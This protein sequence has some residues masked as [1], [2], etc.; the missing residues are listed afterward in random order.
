MSDQIEEAI[1]GVDWMKLNRCIISFSD[2]SMT[3]RGYCFPLIKKAASRVN[4]VILGTQVGD[5]IGHVTSTRDQETIAFSRILEDHVSC[6]VGQPRSL[7]ADSG[8]RV[9]NSLIDRSVAEVTK[10]GEIQVKKQRVSCSDCNQSFRKKSELTRHYQSKH[11]GL[12]WQCVD[13]GRIYKSRDNLKRHCRKRHPSVEST[14]TIGQIEGPS[15]EFD[16]PGRVATCTVI[17][18]SDE[19]IPEREPEQPDV[20][21]SPVEFVA[22]QQERF[23]QA[24]QITRDRLKVTAQKRKSY[25]DLGV[26]AKQFP[27]GS[28][29]WYY[30][31]ATV[32]EEVE[33]S[34]VLFMW[35]HTKSSNGCRTSRMSSRKSPR[36]KELVVHVDKLKLCHSM[37]NDSGEPR[38]IIIV[39]SID[40]EQ[41]SR[42]V[43]TLF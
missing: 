25:Y 22:K 18:E 11:Q 13:C 30:Y 29:V 20:D 19:S 40:L 2:C 43:E 1:I 15:P 24:Y 42:L 39:V 3:L 33:K 9:E 17:P 37:E 10:T 23:R 32:S 41:R 7:L 8:S 31:P 34:G 27:V 36:D 21:N 6:L 16:F 35:G 12:K 38:S 28:S 5:P 26:R 4:R 14:G